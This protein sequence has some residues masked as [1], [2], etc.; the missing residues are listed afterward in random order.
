MAERTGR[1]YIFDTGAEGE[2]ERL[3]GLEAVADSA[4]KRHLLSLGLTKGWRCLEVAAGAGSIAR[5][6]SDEVGS[7]GTVTATDLVTTLLEPLA[8]ERANVEVRRHDLVNEPLEEGAY[9]LIHVR[10]LLEHLPERDELVAKLAGALAP[11]GWL[12]IEDADLGHPG[13]GYGRGA[14]VV[15]G[16]LI[17]VRLM[18]RRH[19]YDPKWARRV[20]A[21][22]AQA[23]LEDVGAEGRSFYVQGGSEPALLLGHNIDRLRALLDGTST[24]PGASAPLPAL[25]QRSPRIRAALDRPLAAAERA[26][27]D[28]KF[29]YFSPMVISAWGRRPPA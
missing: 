22:L 24:D 9:D 11:G 14:R 15:P 5:F 10:F 8:A 3:G 18:L 17:A 1:A 16:F 25:A 13:M 20:A 6:L 4:T 12:L 28:P 21:R 19:G 23:G 2:G 7:E 26:F 27:R 29:S